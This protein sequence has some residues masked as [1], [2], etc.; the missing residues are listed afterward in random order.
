MLSTL[1]VVEVLTDAATSEFNVKAVQYSQL[2]TN[3]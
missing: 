2:L 3:R 1:S